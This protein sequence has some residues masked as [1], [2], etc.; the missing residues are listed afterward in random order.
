MTNLRAPMLSAAFAAL[1]CSACNFQSSPAE[2]LRFAAP[3]GWKPSPGILGFMQFWRSPNG[4]DELLMLFKS[5]E[6]LTA[7]D[8]FSNPQLHDE[9]QGE[10]VERREPIKIC[11]GQPATYVEGRG[12]TRGRPSQVSIVLTDVAGTS[13]LAVYARPV[14]VSPNPAALAALREVCPKP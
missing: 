12:T 1:L 9:L 8:I 14:E 6:K 13:Y 10:S 5:P 2:G 3:P 7:K 4:D 11:G